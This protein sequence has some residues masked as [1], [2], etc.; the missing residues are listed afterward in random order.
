[1]ECEKCGS[2]KKLIPAGISKKTGE[3]YKAF[4]VCETCNPRSKS[5][6]GFQQNTAQ[7]E[8]IM[9]ALRMIYSDIQLLKAKNEDIPVIE[10]EL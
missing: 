3:P 5:N 8:E 1:M 4:Y 2:E 10:D 6:T 9:K 7:H